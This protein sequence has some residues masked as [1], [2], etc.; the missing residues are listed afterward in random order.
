VAGARGLAHV[1]LAVERTNHGARRLYERR[2]YVEWSHGEV[3]D[4]WDE[5]ANDGTVLAHHREI[6]AYLVLQRT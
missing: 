2:G 5:L 1:G 3:V 4:D 6:C